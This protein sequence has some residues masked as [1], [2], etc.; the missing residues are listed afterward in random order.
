MKKTAITKRLTAVCLLL[1]VLAGMFPFTLASAG[2]RTV[3]PHTGE[4]QT[5][6]G[7]GGKSD[8]REFIGRLNIPDVGINV[9][10]Y[11]NI[12][13]KTVD[14]EDSA[15]CL[16]MPSFPDC[17]VI[18]DHSTQEFKTLTDVTEGMLGFIMNSDGSCTLLRCTD[19]CDGHNTEYTITDE[20]YD[21]IIGTSDYLMYTCRTCW[22]NVR[23]CRWEIIEPGMNAPDLSDAGGGIKGFEFDGIIAELKGR[24]AA[25]N[26]NEELNAVRELVIEHAESSGKNKVYQYAP[27]AEQLY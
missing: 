2:T 25:E 8:D 16:V 21:N 22:Q 23:V 1:C 19:V 9:S 13:Q 27:G 3:L 15:G 6:P 24:L 7:V 10:L 4:Q 17:T 11:D 26:I 12:S 5:A 14:R 20:N 18:A